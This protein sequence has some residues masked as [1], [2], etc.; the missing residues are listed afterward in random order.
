MFVPQ[1]CEQLNEIESAAQQDLQEA[2]VILFSP[3]K[4][5]SHPENKN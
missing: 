3:Y 4:N 2:L 5:L 1:N